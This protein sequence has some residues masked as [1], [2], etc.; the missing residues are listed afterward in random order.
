MKRG[1]WSRAATRFFQSSLQFQGTVTVQFDG[2]GN[3]QSTTFEGSFKSALTTRGGGEDSTRIVDG[4]YEQQVNAD[5]TITGRGVEAETR[6]S[7]LGRLPDGCP[8]AVLLAIGMPPGVAIGDA[9]KAAKGERLDLTFEGHGAFDLTNTA[10]GVSIAH[11]DLGRDRDL[12]LRT[13]VG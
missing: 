9:I 8:R 1:P 10:C 7:G 3:F 11:D 6:G 5:G 12:P 13:K 2:E 4:H